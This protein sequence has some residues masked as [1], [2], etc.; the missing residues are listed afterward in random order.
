VTAEAAV[1][2]RGQHPARLAGERLL[3]V[4]LFGVIALLA[5]A[6]ILISVLGPPAEPAGCAP[7]RPCLPPERSL[8]PLRVGSVWQSSAFGFEL[9]YDSR[10]WTAVDEDEE[11]IAL[12]GDGFALE[13]KLTERKQL[14]RA[15]VDQLAELRNRYNRSFQP[16]ASP[17]RRILGPS[18]GYRRGLGPEA[19]ARAYCGT[20]SAGGEMA[21]ADV[22]ILA[23]A[24][25]AAG[26]IVTVESDDCSKTAARSGAFAAADR[27]LNSVLW[28]TELPQ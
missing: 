4:F 24:D 16:N 5:L 9:E 2:S 3:L 12:V 26:A 20:A 21:Q 18:I 6:G 27:V 1:F 17:A 28:P 19:G 23:A 11:A 15:L 8:P 13:V 25:R 14:R 22:V 7:S 10:V